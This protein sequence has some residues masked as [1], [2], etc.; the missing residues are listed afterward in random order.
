MVRKLLRNSALILQPPL[1]TTIMMWRDEVKNSRDL[2]VLQWP[3]SDTSNEYYL[4]NDETS[5]NNRI[6]IE[7]ST[8]RMNVYHKGNYIITF[9]MMKRSSLAILFPM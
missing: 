9:P 3:Q 2:F 7:S 6:Y 1:N 8:F 4:S 5:Y